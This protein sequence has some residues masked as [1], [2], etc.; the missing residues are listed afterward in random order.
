MT[1]RITQAYL[2]NHVNEKVGQLK[3]LRT[4][5]F[6]RGIRTFYIVSL[7]FLSAEWRVDFELLGPGWRVMSRD[8]LK[9]VG[10]KGRAGID[11]R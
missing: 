10:E 1:D 3:S 2:T 8:I 11:V 6:L 7:V 9:R 4:G 5:I